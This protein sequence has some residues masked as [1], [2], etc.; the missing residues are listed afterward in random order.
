MVMKT[1]RVVAATILLA[2]LECGGATAVETSDDRSAI[3]AAQAARIAEL[4]GP[5]EGLVRCG[6]RP[7]H[8]SYKLHIAIIEGVQKLSDRLWPDSWKDLTDDR[9]S[10][11]RSDVLAMAYRA[12][13]AASERGRQVTQQWC[14]STGSIVAPALDEFTHWQK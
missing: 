4:A 11:A 13:D 5:A 8:W 9:P 6:I 12:I 1:Q 7:E 10:A 3:V 2:I 14:V